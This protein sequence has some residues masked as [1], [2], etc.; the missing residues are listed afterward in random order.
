MTSNVPTASRSRRAHARCPHIWKAAFCSSP[1]PATSAG[2]FVAFAIYSHSTSSPH[3]LSN[4]VSNGS[5]LRASVSN[6]PVAT[7]YVLVYAAANVVNDY[8]L[9]ITVTRQTLGPR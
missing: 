1:T 9:T 8:S 5:E 4:G 2:E 7:Y 6:L 3:T